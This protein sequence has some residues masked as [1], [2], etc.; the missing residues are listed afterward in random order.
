M[1]L[2]S[3][4][5]GTA[6]HFRIL[7]DPVSPDLI[8]INIRARRLFEQATC[9]P[10]R[11]CLLCSISTSSRSCKN[12]IRTGGYTRCLRLILGTTG[13]D[14]RGIVARHRGRHIL[15]RSILHLRLALAAI[16]NRQHDAILRAACGYIGASDGWR[17]FARAVCLRGSREAAFPLAVRRRCA[18]SR[19]F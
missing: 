7:Y 9:G 1:Y 5:G 16:N 8:Q 15:G 14:N 17:D 18:R 4:T 10:R 6:H 13:R 19:A 2:V 12:P 3:K 11:S